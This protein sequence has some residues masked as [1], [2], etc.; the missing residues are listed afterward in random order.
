MLGARVLPPFPWDW[1]LV[2]DTESIMR[3][4]S[5]QTASR[6][7][8]AILFLIHPFSLYDDPGGTVCL[9]SCLF[10]DGFWPCSKVFLSLLT[11]LTLLQLDSFGPQWFLLGK[12][13]SGSA[14]YIPLS[15]RGKSCTCK[16]RKL[17]RGLWPE[18]NLQFW[19]QHL[20]WKPT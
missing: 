12:G 16:I 3:V 17:P 2:A 11:L 6:Y 1:S 9:P 15:S 14:Q 5:S 18:V 20:I 13:P 19:E 4:F 7:A 10:S 8:S